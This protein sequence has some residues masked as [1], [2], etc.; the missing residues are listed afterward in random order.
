MYSMDD[1][2]HL[3]H[4]DGAEALQV[5]VGAPPVVIMDG[6]PQQLPGTALTRGDTEHLLQCIADSRQRRELRTRGYVEFHYR[7]RDRVNFIIRARM[8]GEEI[9]INV[10]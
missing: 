4:S 8:V 6:V 9:Q 5:H 2:L 3:L 10:H 7:F 1:L